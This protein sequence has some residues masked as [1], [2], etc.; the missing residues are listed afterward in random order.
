[1]L[2]LAVL[3][4]AILSSFTALAG[5][6]LRGALSGPNVANQTAY[7]GKLTLNGAGGWAPV[8]TGA[9]II[10]A[11]ITSGNSAGCYQVDSGGTISAKN[12]A[13]C[14]GALPGVTLGLSYDGGAATA[15]ITINTTT[16]NYGNSLTNAYSIKDSSEL[17]A[18][19]IGLG[20]A[21]ISGKD[22]FYRYNGGTPYTPPNLY[23]SQDSYLDMV[24]HQSHDHSNMAIITNWRF[25]STGAGVKTGNVYFGY[26][27]FTR[28]YDGSNMVEFLDVPVEHVIFD[29][30]IFDGQLAPYPTGNS[31]SVG[32]LLIDQS[33]APV[34]DL[35]ISNSLFTNF[36]FAMGVNGSNITITG[37]ECAYLWGDCID[38]GSPN[39][40]TNGSNIL[41]QN[42][43]DHDMAGN[44]GYH[45]DF[46]QAFNDVYTGDIT[47]VQVL[48][49]THWEGPAALN[50]GAGWGDQFIILQ[51]LGPVPSVTPGA[52]RRWTIDGNVS[53]GT[54][55]YGIGLE[56]PTYD[57]IVRYNTMARMWPNPAITLGNS[58]NPDLQDGLLYFAQSISGNFAQGNAE[59]GFADVN[60][61]VTITGPANYNSLSRLSLTS[62]TNAFNNGGGSFFQA[63]SQASL[64][65]NY[66]MKPNGPLD[67][68]NNG[69]WSTADAG[70]V[71]T[72]ATNGRCD[73]TTGQINP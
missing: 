10:S 73:F 34:N 49:N 41:I 12:G 37:N 71:G 72:T 22:I 61:N 1:M 33:H 6:S 64:I 68:N 31:L 66:R 8:N 51:K 38:L 44:N 48:C 13:G 62:Y 35:T 23:G 56:Q 58:G 69:V 60:G 40:G 54:A 47:D 27:K 59:E 25:D 55:Q 29:H 26:L 3:I 18:L 24:H 2:R 43:S 36:V 32:P 19:L 46:L 16:D 30:D 53:E 52:Y 15:T 50:Q 39:D 63:T 67:L 5:G 45:P 20:D 17:S 4:L 11:S 42:N 28:P 65:A 9:P 21:V 7:F 70:A 57:S 14:I